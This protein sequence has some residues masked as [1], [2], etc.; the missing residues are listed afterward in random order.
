MGDFTAQELENIANAALD[1][2]IKGPAMDSTI[3]ARPL[4]REMRA[5]QKTFPGGKELITT[6]VKGVR[7]TTIQGYAVDDTVTYGNP[8]N[9]KQAKVNYYEIHA[10]IGVSHTELKKDGIS[11]VDTDGKKTSAHSERDL[12]VITSLLEDKLD[13]MTEGYAD[14]MQTMYWQDGTQD[15]KLIPGITS[16]IL[17]AP[18]AAGTTMGLD[19]TANTWWRNRATLAI[20]SST[21]TNQNLVNVLQAE[22][23]QLRRY[24]KSPKHK[25]FA[26]SDFMDAFEKELRAKGNYT[27]EGWAKGGGGVIDASI[28]D[29]AFKGIA[30]E[31]DPTLDDIGRSKYGY[32]LDMKHIMPKVM[33]GEDNKTH[34]PSRPPEKYMMYRAMTYTGG[35]IANQLNSSGVYSIA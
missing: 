7:S 15:A 35:L 17:D 4:Y 3:Q 23:R 24:E 19:R 11:V 5:A 6:N 33:Q 16:F 12:T 10:G 8:A 25:F 27:L 14:G 34:S 26:G 20:D 21:A 31:Y 18:A 22:F 9:I 30:I 29:L 13:D 32:V 1:F 2:H 28:A